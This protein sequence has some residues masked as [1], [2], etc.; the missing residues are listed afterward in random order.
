ADNTAFANEAGARGREVTRFSICKRFGQ[1]H[2][3]PLMHV[4]CCND[5]R[6]MRESAAM[7]TKK[8]VAAVDP[9]SAFSK[10]RNK[11]KVSGKRFAS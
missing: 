10:S 4:N 6:R 8:K 2:R 9:L 11:P 3:D 1:Q 5:E 7:A